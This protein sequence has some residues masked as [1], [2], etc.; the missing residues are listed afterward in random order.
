[1]DEPLEKPSEEETIP[2]PGPPTDVK[3]PPPGPPTDIKYE[4]ESYKMYDEQVNG[5]KAYGEQEKQKF[6]K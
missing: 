1:M 6:Y 5:Q 2:P 3:K 4:V